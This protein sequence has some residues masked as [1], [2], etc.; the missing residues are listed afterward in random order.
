MI[1][2]ALNNFLFNSRIQHQDMEKKKNLVMN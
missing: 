1:M 2:N